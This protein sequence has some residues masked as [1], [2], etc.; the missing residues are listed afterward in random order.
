MVDEA[1]T[2]RRI[3]VVLMVPEWD[4][5]ARHSFDDITD[6]SRVKRAADRTNAVQ[7]KADADDPQ[8]RDMA[9]FGAPMAFGY[10]LT[11]QDNKTNPLRSKREFAEFIDSLR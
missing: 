9:I 8:L 7:L 3:A 4:Q 10:S 2:E 5:A 1:R 11:N 6:N